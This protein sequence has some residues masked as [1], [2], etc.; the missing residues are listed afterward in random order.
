MRHQNLTLDDVLDALMI[1][2]PDPTYEA[3]TRWSQRYPEYAEALANF[4]AT[5]AVQTELPQENSADGERLANLAVSHALDIVHRRDQTAERAPK[6]SSARP[7][8]IASARAVGISEEQL[9]IRSGLD[10]TIIDKLDLRRISTGIP[11]ICFEQLATALGTFTDH[12]W[13]MTTGPP[14]LAA[15]TR[16]K[17]KRKPV[18]T[19]EDF[20]DAIR[21]SSLSEQ[22][23][24]F[25]LEAVAAEHKSSEK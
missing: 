23:K 1:E 5:W 6:T 25:W 8:L 13:E 12:I 4:F 11:R 10:S 14:L 20:A 24:R 19:T 17:A 22:A 9:A 3:L 15:G 16:H 2:E 21:N 7:R 18:P